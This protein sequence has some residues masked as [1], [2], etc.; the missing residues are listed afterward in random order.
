MG[1]TTLFRNIMLGFSFHGSKPVKASERKDKRDFLST[2]H[3]E[4]ERR[5]GIVSTSTI[6]NELTAYRSFLAFAGTK[7][8]MS[9]LTGDRMKAYE[10]W[11]LKKSVSRNTSACYMRSLRSVFN[12]LGLDGWALFKDVRT[13]KDLAEKRALGK[14]EVKMI[15]ETDIKGHKFITCA[16]DLFLFSLMAMGIPFIDLIHLRKTS[17]KDGFLIYHRRKTGRQAKV[18]LEPCLKE[19]IARY[20]REDSPFLFPLLSEKPNADSDWAYHN[21]LGRYNRALG[22]ISQMAG[23]S[24]RITSYTARHTWA[25]I[26]YRKGGSLGAISKALTHA[27]PITTQNYLKELDDREIIEVNRL[28]LK[29]FNTKIIQI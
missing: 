6:E 7:I 27:T 3:Q 5:R 13:S 8:K 18:Y 11:L 24:R 29:E 10:R 28:V 25:T 2:V 9:D 22:K 23:L 1:Y 21:L 26:A 17:I 14:E 15:M 4:I 20:S 16:R 12:R 19:I